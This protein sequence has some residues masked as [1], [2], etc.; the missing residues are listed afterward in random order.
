MDINTTRT[1]DEAQQ[2][3]SAL[4]QI[5]GSAELRAE[6]GSNMDRVLNR[7]NLSG[8]AR[9]AVALGIASMLVIPAVGSI[10]SLPEVFWA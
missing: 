3:L 8:V 4:E 2:I 10:G 1:D 7:F 9:H 6:A 5:Q